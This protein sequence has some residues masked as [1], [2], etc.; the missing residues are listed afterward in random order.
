MCP[1]TSHV[2]TK[3]GIFIAKKVCAAGLTIRIPTAHIYGSKDNAVSE[4]LRLR[5]MCDARRRAEFDHGCGHEVPRAPK[6]A[7]QMAETINRAVNAALT[8]V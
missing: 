1:A 8:A 6:L 5:D 3:S 7:S 2:Q 4:S